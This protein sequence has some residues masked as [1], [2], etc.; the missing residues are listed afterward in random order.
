MRKPE[1]IFLRVTITA[2]DV[3]RARG[4]PLTNEQIQAYL[5]YAA[6]DQALSDQL[7]EAIQDY[8]AYLDEDWVFEGAD[9]EEYADV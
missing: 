3:L 4:G 1:T 7:I 9:E 5:D 8:L 2:D 6:D